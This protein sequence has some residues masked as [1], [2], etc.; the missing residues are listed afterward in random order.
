MNGMDHIRFLGFPRQW[1]PI[2]EYFGL[3]WRDCSEPREYMPIIS[4][5]SDDQF[6]LFCRSAR[7]AGMLRSLVE[8]VSVLDP[9]LADLLYIVDHSMRIPAILTVEQTDCTKK[10]I[11]LSSWQAYGRPEILQFEAAV[12]QV[13][14]SKSVAVL[15]PCSRKRPYGSSRTHQK[16]WKI[17]KGLGHEPKRVDQVV[18][19]SLGVVPEALW[20]HPVVMRYDAGVP[21]VYRVLRLARRFFARN[22]YTRII[23]CLQFVPYSD[24]FKILQREKIVK[25]VSYCVASKSRQFYLKT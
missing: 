19:T 17:L 21:D 1:I 11:R 13:W 9:L 6:A 24:I 3:E 20:D 7:A 10:L 4:E 25:R 8:S 2:F 5:I 22:S 12:D 15:L 14:K 16:I 18:I 23:D